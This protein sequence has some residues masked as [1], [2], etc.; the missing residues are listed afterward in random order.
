[1][2]NLKIK[3][4]FANLQPG[5]SSNWHYVVC[6]E[7]KRAR[8]KN[9]DMLTVFIK[10]W[11]VKFDSLCLSEAIEMRLYPSNRHKS[12]Q[13]ATLRKRKIPLIRTSTN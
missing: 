1:M 9:S 11:N 10:Y 8:V 7:S 6:K 12:T 13:Y 3:L 4:G 2:S 5:T